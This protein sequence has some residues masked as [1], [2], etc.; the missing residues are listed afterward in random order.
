MLFEVILQHKSGG[1]IY[2]KTDPLHPRANPAGYYP[3]HRVVVEN[4]IGKVLDPKLIV[5]HIDEDKTNN[6]LTNL[7]VLTA[8]EHGK[9]HRLELERIEVVCPHCYI[10][11]KLK[12]HVYR[13]RLKRNISGKLFCSRSCGASKQRDSVAV[14]T[15]GS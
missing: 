14:D 4:S 2:C 6:D 9:L 10:V 15:Y 1:Y 13:V 5:H 12:P 3:L 8:S 7:Q 11:F